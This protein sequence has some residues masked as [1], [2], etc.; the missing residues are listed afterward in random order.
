MMLLAECSGTDTTASISYMLLSRKEVVAK[1][2]SLIY[3]NCWKDSTTAIPWILPQTGYV[4]IDKVMNPSLTS[5][6]R[7]KVMPG[8]VPATKLIIPTTRSFSTIK[9]SEAYPLD[10]MSDLTCSNP[11][12]RIP[13]GNLYRP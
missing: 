3:S 7:K 6:F 4:R 11:D 9:T 10:V 5:F 12:S 2:F 13:D 1:G 8:Y